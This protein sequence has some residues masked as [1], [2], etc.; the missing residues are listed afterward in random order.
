M[1][2]PVIAEN[3]DTDIIGFK[4]E[5]HASDAGSE[6]D[7]LTG[8]DLIE[9]DN[10]GNTVADAND[11][12]KLLDII[13]GKGSITT[14]VMFMIL[15]WITLAVSAIPN[16]LEENGTLSFKMLLIMLINK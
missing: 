14:W 3:D 1:R 16:F 5:G 12:A 8:L 9:A 7:H 10:S 2:V 4:I 6:L 13:L 11:C 15:S